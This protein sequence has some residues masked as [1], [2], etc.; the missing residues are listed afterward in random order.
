MNSEKQP[1]SYAELSDPERLRLL[2]CCSELVRALMDCLGAAQGQLMW[3]QLRSVLGSELHLDLLQ[4][5]LSTDVKTRDLIRLVDTGPHL[6]SCIRILREHS[7][8]TLYDAK[9]VTDA[10][11]SGGT[12][13]IQLYA[14]HRSQTIAELRKIGARAL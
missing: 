8:L 10:V 2:M 14:G 12:I 7:Y 13:A 1:T 4:H 3:D 5:L 11:K 6:V 9:Q